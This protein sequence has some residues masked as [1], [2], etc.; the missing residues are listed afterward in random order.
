[1]SDSQ[2]FGGSP[3]TQ[4]VEQ[5]PVPAEVDSSSASRFSPKL[6]MV[7]GG[8]IVV[9]ALAAYFLLFS[10]GSSTDTSST[11]GL[12]PAAPHT[13]TAPGKPGAS[14]SPTAAPAVVGGALS[15]SGRDPFQ[16]LVTAASPT[17]S[18][19]AN[20]TTGSTTTGGTT[21]PAGVKSTL[22]VN[23]VNFATSSATVTVDGKPYIAYAGQ[24]FAKYYTL[25]VVIAGGTQQCAVFDFGDL[26]A[27]VCKGQSAI[28]TG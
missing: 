27:Q 4:V 25:K 2:K 19:S 15:A 9:L 12:V 24:L 28:F 7:I 1:M 18:T 5:E 23:A 6:L 13:S 22:T 10:G 11:S 8:V 26:P 3:A 20:S 16:P 17:P 14:A 21:T